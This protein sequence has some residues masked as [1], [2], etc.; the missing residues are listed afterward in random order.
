MQEK[1]NTVNRNK[2]PDLKIDI[3]FWLQKIVSD[4]WIFVIG[5]AIFIPAGQL[6][7]R[8]TVPEYSSKAKLLIK[9]VGNSGGLSEAS[10]LTEGL[11]IKASGKDMDNE[12]QILRS[13]PVITRVVEKLNAH[14]TIF[15]K[16]LV[17][18]TDLYGMAPF[19]LERFTIP[20]GKRQ[21]NFYIKVDYNKKFEFRVEPDLEGENLYSFGEKFS[22]EYGDFQLSL[23]PEEKVF[24]GIYQIKVS[25]PQDVANS[26]KNKVT[27]E[28]IGKQGASGILELKL[29]DPSPKKARDFVN[30]LIEVYNE[31][32]VFENTLVF[33][34]TIEFID[35]RIKSLTTELNSIES[36]I[37]RFKSENDIISQTAE[38]SLD[39]NLEE[40]RSSL[41]KL[42]SYEVEKDVL[43]SLEENLKNNKNDL[44]PT[45]ISNTNS[46]LG[47]LIDEYNS[48]FLKRKRL[49][50]I[51]SLTNDRI[52]N[53]DLRLKDLKKLIF[54]TLAIVKKD[55]QI[56][57]KKTRDEISKLKRNLTKIPSV[58]KRL[59]EKL[60]M[61]AIKEN[62]FLFLLQKREETELSN[63]ITTANTRII[64]SALRARSPI[65]PQKKLTL[66]ASILLGA[67][68][69]LIFIL[70]KILL[71]RK[72]DSEDAITRITGVPIIGRISR[73]TSKE[74]KFLDQKGRTMQAEMFK[75]LR[76]NLNYTN[77]EKKQQILAI[78]SSSTGEGKSVTAINLGLTISFSEKKVV[79]IDMDLRKPKLA[80]YMG[81]GNEKGVTSYLT[82]NNTLKEIL[83]KTENNEYCYFI[84]S[85]PI[86]PNPTEMIMSEKMKQLIEE[87]KK[88][89]DYIIMD[90]PPIGVVSDALLLREFITNTLYI[91]RNKYTL[92][93]SIHYLEEQYQNGELVNPFIVVNDIKIRKNGSA[94]KG[95][96]SNYGSDYYLKES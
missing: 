12:I 51:V 35:K 2:T 43:S 57:T 28:V 9:D 37:E 70:L 96:V 77:L 54:R 27:I 6:Y 8:Y 47:G 10:I 34:N 83:H 71:E 86:P 72:V 18:S 48:L 73:N 84:S 24:A 95:Y 4:W 46:S 21:F 68:L 45:N 41:G 89:F 65:F 87:L 40:L 25:D 31:D 29:I 53:L 14:V 56:P 69:P 94:Y 16:G 49:L 38:A 3:N 13:R 78:T 22:N 39:Y 64:E 50:K 67:F 82:G 85:G 75:L 90:S 79:I 93:S 60:R 91:V 81:L 88:E 36:D 15:R 61:Q 52:E 63:A 44:I 92:R 20:S 11:G 26:F 62:L 17:K 58:E 5:L 1:K 59:L 74:K 19:K 80:K 55:L 76:T 7:L 66:V 30:T 23:I 33:K 32:Q 42:S